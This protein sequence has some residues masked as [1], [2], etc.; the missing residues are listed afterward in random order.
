MAIVTIIVFVFL[1]VFTSG[2]NGENRV[3]VAHLV[4]GKIT[5]TIVFTETSEGLHITG[6]IT[7]LPA[8]RYGFHVH[9]LGDTSTCDAAGPHFDPEGNN[10]GGP[11][12]N[13]RHVGDLGN[14]VFVGNQEPVATVNFV[15]RLITLR[16]KNN[17][18]G[19]TLV[20]HEQEDDLGLGGHELSLTTGNAGPRVACGVIGIRSPVVWNSAVTSFPLIVLYVLAAVF[21]LF[22][23]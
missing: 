23:N 14:V 10:H 2:T 6:T 7:G 4:S 12:H 22:L 19:R 8:G 21:L 13:V 9:A 16:G 20:L 11:D 1:C 15:D 5:G 17:I 18:I 3:A